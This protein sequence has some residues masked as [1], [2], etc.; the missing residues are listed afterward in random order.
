MPPNR[1]RTWTPAQ[2]LRIVI[3]TLRSDTKLAEICR[4]EGVSPNMVY[5][6]KWRKQLM[7]SAESVFRPKPNNQVDPRVEQL[8]NENQRMK[9]VIAEVT[10]ENLVL[11]KKRRA[12]GFG[13][14]RTCVSCIECEGD[15]RGALPAR[16]S[17]RPAAW[18]KGGGHMINFRCPSPSCNAPVRFRDDQAGQTSRCP[19]CGRTFLVAPPLTSHGRSRPASDG[20]REPSPEKHHPPSAAPSDGASLHRTATSTLRV[21]PTEPSAADQAFSVVMARAVQAF[22]R[23][24][25]REAARWIREARRQPGCNRHPQAVDLWGRCYLRLPRRGLTQAWESATFEGH[26]AGVTSVSMSGD[27]RYAL[28]GSRDK[29]LKLWDVPARRCVRTF[30]GH[31]DPVFSVCLGE[32]ARYALSG[33]VRNTLRLWDVSTGRCLRTFRGPG[34]QNWVVAVCLSADGRYALSGG[35]RTLRLWDVN[36]SGCLKT[37][38][39]DDRRPR[40]PPVLFEGAYPLN[41]IVSICLTSDGRYALSAGRDNKLKLWDVAAA[42]CLRTFEGHNGDVTSVCLSADGNLAL[43]ASYDK[44]LRLWDLRTDCCLRTF[45]GHEKAVSSGCLAR[46][47]RF[48]VSGSHDKAIK[49]WETASGRCLHTFR[50]HTAPV[51]SVFL[52]PDGRYILSGSLDQT[53][54]L[55]VLDWE[56]EEKDPADRHEGAR[57]YL[58]AFLCAHMPYAGALPHNRR[59]TPEEVAAALTRRGRPEW[60]EEDF[61]DLVYRLGCAGYGWLRAEGVRRELV[62]V[63]QQWHDPLA[64]RA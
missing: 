6:Y 53:L 27:G 44:T 24:E 12:W 8:A 9:D 48:A 58:Q 20:K 59:P 32:D 52:T 35:E 36:E 2:K 61:A 26:S 56:L 7:A 41:Q 28:S 60:D 11:R 23:G 21:A 49:V 5:V 4:R 40:I 51:S 54:R 31:D 42:R 50:G 57:P 25:T 30:E 22:E 3:E 34:E 13:S 63:S 10:A 64:T 46:D 39:Q 62:S 15:H 38:E 18:A 1:R 17:T 29:T 14:A 16:L 37:F 55:W 33:D 43:S 47:G 45:E 19:K